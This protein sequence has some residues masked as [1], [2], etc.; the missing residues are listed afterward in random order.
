MKR[1]LAESIGRT[2]LDMVAGERQWQIGKGHDYDHD[3][4]HG[5]EELAVAAAMLLL[6]ADMNPDIAWAEDNRLRQAPLIEYIG[7]RTFDV[8]R[9]D[10]P[11][12]L[13]DPVGVGFAG[14]LDTRIGVLVKGL[15]MGV[16]ELERLMRIREEAGD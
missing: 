6:P 2:A 11:L 3:D 1:H 10:V 15:A 9:T 4:Q 12:D 8:V 7:G 5:M 16:A 14:R 13:P